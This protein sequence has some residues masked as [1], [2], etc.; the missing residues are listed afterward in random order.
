[1]RILIETEAKRV[2]KLVMIR[3]SKRIFKVFATILALLC[4][5]LCANKTIKA[6]NPVLRNPVIKEDFSMNAGQG[7]TWDC[8]WFGNYPQADVTTTEMSGNY[9]SANNTGVV[10]SDEE[11]TNAS[12]STNVSVTTDQNIYYSADQQR[13]KVDVTVTTEEVYEEGTHKYIGYLAVLDGG[14]QQIK[15]WFIPGGIV[16]YTFTLNASDY[17]KDGSTNSTFAA[18]VFPVDNFSEGASLCDHLFQVFFL[19]SSYELTYDANGGQCD[20][21]QDSIIYNCAYGELPVPRRSGYTFDGWYTSALG[22]QRITEDTVVTVMKEQTLYAHWIP[23]SYTIILNAN[24]G[25]CSPL[26]IEGIY[27]STY[28]ALEDVRFFFVPEGYIF[29][30]WYTSAE[31]GTRIL[32]TTKISIPADHTIYA[33]WIRETEPETPTTEPETQTTESERPEPET[34]STEPETPATES[35]MPGTNSGKADFSDEKNLSTQIHSFMEHKPVLE[36]KTA[37]ANQV[38]LIWKSV[39]GAQKYYIYYATNA[40]GKYTLAKTVSSSQSSVILRKLKKNKIYYFKIK[41]SKVWKEKN[42]YTKESKIVSKKVAGSLPRPVL[43][44]QKPKGNTLVLKWKRQK[45]VQKVV[46]YK[47]TGGGFKKYKVLDGKKTSYKISLKKMDKTKTCSFCI[48]TYYIQ[49][50][51]KIW[52]S[53]VSKVIKIVYK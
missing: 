11:K 22:G 38:K 29:D 35:E 5:I 27:G 9:S 53:N 34:P 36:V 26:S 45:G 15:A 18:A 28:T 44:R 4:M 41:C 8:V 1:M 50:G 17:T 43:K 20:I 49:E 32:E 33:H 16:K 10:Y 25:V 14:W 24:G 39:E 48:K 42:V 21:T 2:C 7:A 52:C 12:Y 6:E 30:G 19:P 47:N 13:F 23:N 37:G 51:V 31:G 3:F 40:N 46:I